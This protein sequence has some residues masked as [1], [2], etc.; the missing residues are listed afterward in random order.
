MQPSSGA[1]VQF[2]PPRDPV[3]SVIV[4]ATGAAP[5]LM[6]CLRALAANTQDVPFEVI[7]VE[8]GLEPSTSDHLAF[9]AS[10]VTIVRSGVNR[11]F[12]GGCNLGARAAKGAFLALLN[13][14]AEPQPGWLGP[15]LEAAGSPRVDAV[16][17]RVL[18]ADGTL[19]EA[20]SILWDDGST[21]GVGRGVPGDTIS[22]RFRRRV[23]YCS[24]LSFL[25][26]R[27]TWKELGGLDES[28]FPAYCEDVDLCL[29]IAERGGVVLYEPRS[30]VR[31]FESRSSTQRFKEYLCLTHRR[32]L[33]ERWR[34]VLES[35][36][37]QASTD[38]DAIEGAIQLAMGSPP[39][40]LVIDDR[41][42]DS[43][44]GSGYSRMFEVVRDIS[45]SGYRV[46][47]FPTV[48]ADV[49]PDVLGALGVGVVTEPLEEHLRRRTVRYEAVLISR[50]HNY[51]RFASLVRQLQPTARLCYDAEALFHRRLDA[52]AQLLG[53][54]PARDA[55]CIAARES[56]KV[57]AEIARTLDTLV[58]VSADEAAA[59]RALGARDPLVVEPW[60]REPAL[61]P[62]GFAARSD[63][64]M[65]A[66]WLA[67]PDS[68]NVDGLL[69][70][71]RGGAA[72]RPGAGPVGPGTGVGRLAA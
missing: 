69:W 18:H 14:D 17:G 53:P 42:P 8:N 62:A 31:H 10:G 41:V 72:A 19:Q 22:L 67:G 57:E 20:G 15:L 4:V 58:C 9:A 6:G 26:R 52:Q 55:L 40:V 61:T 13:D 23:D 29:R 43:R 56:R 51:S 37:P 35:R 39:R 3:V 36:T 27:D 44:L 7:V 60:L 5:Y 28:Y 59:L 50:P 25:V 16:G 45:T 12:A 1:V 66:G 21:S 64:L 68:P 47:V 30:V 24:A 65:V 34:D 49:D 32:K 11:G 2:S 48:P 33:V 63:V 70:F 46:S 71:A 38:P 54:G